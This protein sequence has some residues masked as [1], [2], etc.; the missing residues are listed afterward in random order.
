MIMMLWDPFWDFVNVCRHVHN[1]IPTLLLLPNLVL[2]FVQFIK[3]ETETQLLKI[4]LK[5]GSDQTQFVKPQL[6]RFPAAQEWM[7]PTYED[8]ILL[9]YSQ[10]AY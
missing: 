10:V 9:P 6:D 7:M 4:C 2:I 1:Y 8:E 3:K 5:S